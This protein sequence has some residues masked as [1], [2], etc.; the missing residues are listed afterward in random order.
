MGEGWPAL[1]DEGIGAIEAARGGTELL[2]GGEENAEKLVQAESEKGIVKAVKPKRRR[3]DENA[4][5]KPYAS[6]DRR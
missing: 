2:G 3:S 1:V 5:G 6:S 4:K